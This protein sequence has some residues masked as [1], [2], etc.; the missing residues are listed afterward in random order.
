MKNT[1]IVT[2]GKMIKDIAMK[3]NLTIGQVKKVYQTMPKYL[4]AMLE[5]K[6]VVKFCEIGKFEA[7]VTKGKTC[8]NLGYKVTEKSKHLEAPH[9]K[10]KFTATAGLKKFCNKIPL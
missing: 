2:T 7:V 5:G 6:N 4:R 10:I 1:N 3:N 9:R 8:D